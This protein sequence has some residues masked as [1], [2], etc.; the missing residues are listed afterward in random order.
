MSFDQS[1]KDE[2]SPVTVIG[3]GEMGQA[4]ANALLKN[5]YNSMEPD[6]RQS[7]SFGGA[8]RCTS[9]N[10][11]RSCESKPRRDRMCSRLRCSA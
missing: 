2:R 7:C 4:L 11:L 8:R 6:G 10:P 9:G 3:L 5:V 1:Q